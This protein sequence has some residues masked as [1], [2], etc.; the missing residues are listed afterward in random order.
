MGQPVRDN[1]K[2]I[3]PELTNKPFYTLIIDGSNLLKISMVDSKINSDGIHYGGIFQF[4]LQLR[5]LLTMDYKYDYVYIVFDDSDSGILRYQIYN[6]YKANRDKNYAK[7][8]IGNAEESDYWKRLNQTLKGMNK[9]II[10]KEQKRKRQNDKNLT[11]EEIHNANIKKINKEIDKENFE[12]ERNILMMYC[13]EMSMRVLFDDKTE[14]DDF[15][16]YYVANKKPEER[17]IIVSTDQDLT[18]LIS[19]T[20]AV[21]NRNLKKYLN[22]KN[23]K[24]IKGYPVENVLLKK[25]F[26]GDVSD[27]IGNIKG[28]SESR[29]ME[30]MPEISERPVT[31]DEVKSRAQEMINERINE[32]KKP[33]QWHENIVNG[34]SNKEYDGDF[35][36]INEKIINLK[37]PL[38]TKQAQSDIEAMMY[39]PME[40]DDNAFNNLYKMIVRDNIQDLIDPN[41]FSRFFVPFKELSD[42]EKRR[43]FEEI[44]EN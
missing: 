23:F 37:K 33:L 11:D 35:Y 40:P 19:P 39:A 31:I 22:I 41:A 16:A 10:K 25:I 1:I 13:V 36:E 21:Y 44:G 29:L 18:Q 3:Y 17:V 32:K 26:C 4:L 38:L 9:A 20:V 28:L 34:V 14:G 30:L 12:R 7:H 15:I 43:Y 24:K 8:L 2:Q 27:N 5:I 42:R 6:E